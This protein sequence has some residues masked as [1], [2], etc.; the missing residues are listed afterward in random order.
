MT[1]TA[2]KKRNSNSPNATRVRRHRE[3]QVRGEVLAKVPVPESYRKLMVADG[4]LDGWSRDDREAIT[5]AVLAI[6]DQW[7][8]EKA[9]EIGGFLEDVEPDDPLL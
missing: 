4:L 1:R 9:A 5:D 2:A 7:K 3:R 8:L 6:L